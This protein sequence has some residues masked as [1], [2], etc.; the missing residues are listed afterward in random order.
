MHYR[1][2]LK[3]LIFIHVKNMQCRPIQREDKN[4]YVS[5]HI[6]ARSSS[7]QSINNYQIHTWAINAVLKAF[8]T[9]NL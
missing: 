5:M 1:L 8:E 7:E 2:A 3:I 9:K 4:E 6:F